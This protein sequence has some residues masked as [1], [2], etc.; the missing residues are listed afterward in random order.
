MEN[1]AKTRCSSSTT[2]AATEDKPHSPVK[3][4][5]VSIPEKQPMDERKE[6]EGKAISRGSGVMARC[7][8][9]KMLNESTVEIG[10][11]V[12]LSESPSL[13]TLPW[14]ALNRLFTFLYSNLECTDLANMA[15]VS[16][17]LRAMVKE[18]LGSDDNRPG[19]KE[20]TLRKKNEGLEVWMRIFLSNAPFYDLTGLDGSRFRRSRDL[21]T[22]SPAV[23]VMLTGAED[24]VVEQ[25]ARLLSAPV[26]HVDI[27]STADLA[28]CLPLLRASFIRHIRFCLPAL[29]DT[30]APCVL[31]MA[32]RAESVA[33]DL[34]V[35]NGTEGLSDPAAFIKEL[36]STVPSHVYLYNYS[37][38]FFG[39]PNSFWVNFFNEKLSNGSLDWVEVG[40]Q[41]ERMIRAPIILSD[42]HFARVLWMK[43]NAK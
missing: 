24:T 11:R 35:Q 19:L 40:F 34:G 3:E 23:R 42:R 31:S 38:L 7:E 26:G 15:K 41:S 43:S 32:S 36:F 25:A 8:S 37:P 10:C 16:I 28:L 22:S 14:P 21:Y 13:D 2:V 1:A 39:L 17:Y 6:G 30:T 9:R 12:D 18:F 4:D 20:V 27:Q 29:D 5:P 33:I